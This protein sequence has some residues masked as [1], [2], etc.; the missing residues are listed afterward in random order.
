MLKRKPIEGCNICSKLH[1]L[2]QKSLALVLRK[3]ALHINNT[4]S[5]LIN[6]PTI[7]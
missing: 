4:Y 7:T 5:L 2:A 3:C 1:T 6:A